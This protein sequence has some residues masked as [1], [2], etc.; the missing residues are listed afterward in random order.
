[1]DI[2]EGNEQDRFQV[3]NGAY[4]AP[5]APTTPAPPTF[6]LDGE[7]VVL[8]PNATDDPVD[9]IPSVN[10]G[11]QYDKTTFASNRS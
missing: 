5:S 3:E 11:K 6:T 7:T 2:L 4:T 10:S 8:C 9:P 1:M